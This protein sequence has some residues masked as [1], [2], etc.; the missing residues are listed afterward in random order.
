MNAAARELGRWRWKW[1]AK[2]MRVKACRSL[3]VPVISALSR[4]FP[5]LVLCAFQ[6]HNPTNESSPAV[7]CRWQRWRMN[8]GIRLPVELWDEVFTHLSREDL[9]HVHLV[10]HLFH[11]LSNPLLFRTVTFHFDKIATPRS[12]EQYDFSP[13]EQSDSS[14]DEQ[15]DS[16]AV[17][18]PTPAEVAVVE[19][20]LMRLEVWS[21]P[22]I[23]P[24]VRVC[25]I[26][27]P[28]PR[29]FGPYALPETGLP[30][31]FLVFF[32][33]LPNFTSLR[34]FTASHIRFCDVD[35][36]HVCLLP[37]LAKM[38]TRSC[39]M[40]NHSPFKLD[41]SH[42]S[43][44]GNAFYAD[45]GDQWIRAL[46]PDTLQSLSIQRKLIRY[47][48]DLEYT[49]PH[50]NTLIFEGSDLS[51]IAESLPLL[52]KF[53]AVQT[54]TMTS[55]EAI[56]A[57]TN[58]DVSVSELPSIRNFTG[59]WGL[60]RFLSLSHLHHLTL[61]D[62]SFPDFVSELRKIQILNSVTSLAL[63]LEDY[64]ENLDGL[65]ELFPSLKTLAVYVF[66]DFYSSDDE[67]RLINKTKVFAFFK[68]LT[69][70]PSLPMNLTRLDIVWIDGF[71][72][73]FEFSESTVV[74]PDDLQKLKDTLVTR[75]SALTRLELCCVDYRLFWARNPA[76]GKE[77][78]ELYRADD[79]QEKSFDSDIFWD[80]FC[81]H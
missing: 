59:P 9:Q 44:R 63:E 55:E 67:A 13:D 57:G 80:A 58:P 5:N 66:P 3:L 12:D 75:H 74:T 7:L 73:P 8:F 32:H 11:R 2:V 61:T 37:N 68:Q 50:V 62:S 64:L 14:S 38:D 79:P 10:D 51:T 19:N 48:T 54:L 6:P 30:C 15:D 43:F 72:H 34:E 77:Y 35:V 24:L 27:A 31:P 25:T 40:M 36:A 42:F 45:T 46:R 56:P 4:V 53:P 29:R 22:A 1:D 16:P 26:L 33:A 41:V 17:V 65:G 70:F 49:F 28:S 69:D 76:N 78:C 20:A 52:S 39:T 47:I 81:S 60:L 23:A 71:Q 18:P 21:S